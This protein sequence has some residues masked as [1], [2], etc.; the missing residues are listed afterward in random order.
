[1]FENIYLNKK[2]LVTGHT[3]FKG[4][5]LT[6]WLIHLG[7]KVAG[8]SIGIPTNPSH[9]EELNLESKIQH[10]IGDI[11]DFD[12]FYGV[13]EEFEPEFIF[14]LAAQPLV[15]DSYDNPSETFGVNIMGT[16]NVL[17]CI[18][19]LDKIIKVGI[20]ITS[21]KCYDNVEWIYGYRENDQLGGE[22]PYS[23]SKGAAELV[24]KSYIKS[25]FQN[26]DFPRVNT[27]RAGNVIGG[28]DW[29]KDRIVPDI[30]RSWSKGT[31]V[32][33]RNPS[34]TRPWQHVLEPLS[35]Y[36]SLCAD[37]Y[38]SKKNAGEPFNFGPDSKIN[39][40]VGELISEMKTIWEASPGWKNIGT[41]DT[42]R[43]ESNLLK[44]CCDKANLFLEWYPTLDFNETIEFTTIWYMVFYEGKT[45]I[46]DFTFS[47]IDKYVEYATKRK[48]KW[49][50]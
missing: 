14:H 17:E 7:A 28:G 1:M 26:N 25:F 27:V 50:K 39:K 12:K 35:G 30:V 37:L 16:L 15:R 47:Q 45:K 18:R 3:G 13:C 38:T 22:D 41:S 11:R 5:W 2:V 40:N 33:I 20:I 9:F 32:K 49:T 42:I 48:L 19:K 24:A 46:S 36:L 44:L 4:S 8:Y 23:G 43:K 29:A 21:D 34:S 10:Y 31:P 6:S